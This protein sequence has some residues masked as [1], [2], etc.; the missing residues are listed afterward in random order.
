M[1]KY[2]NRESVPSKYKWDLTTIFKD[3]AAFEATL[4]KNS[5]QI[6]ELKNYIGCTKDAQKLYEFITKEIETGAVFENLYVYSYLKNDEV[7]GIAKNIEQKN[8]VLNLSSILDTNTS[9]FAP[10]LLQLS[11]D[12]YQNL[13]IKNPKLNAYKFLLDETYRE[14]E[15]TLTAKE[16]EIIGKL[17]SAMNSYD[18]ISSN[19]INSE[20]D[21]G[22]VKLENGE[23]IP[24]ATNN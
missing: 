15:H 7:L 24:I 14:K 2:S 10:E 22:W 18:D 13:F 3:D 20:H 4:K 5:E 12:Q 6:M 1:Q 9:F 8:K 11:H 23:I 19:L 21:Y 17:V 16:E